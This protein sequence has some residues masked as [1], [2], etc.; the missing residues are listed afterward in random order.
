MRLLLDNIIFNR[1]RHMEIQWVGLAN[2]MIYYHYNK[3]GFYWH[4]DLQLNKKI[5]RSVDMDYNTAIRFKDDDEILQR[6]SD[7]LN[8]KTSVAVAILE[9]MHNEGLS[10]EDWD[11]IDVCLNDIIKHQRNYHGK[12]VVIIGNHAADE[13]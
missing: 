6:A 5:I 12:D 1:T 9:L 7:V 11:F 3:S 8:K 2:K 4:E 10:Y 13:V